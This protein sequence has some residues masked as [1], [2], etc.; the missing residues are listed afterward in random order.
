MDSI[1]QLP[2]S[3]ENFVDVLTLIFRVGLGLVI[4]PHGAQKLLGWY[5]GYGYKGTMGYFSSIGIPYI[6]GMLAIVAEFF[7]S[8]G[9]IFGFLTRISAFGIFFVMLVAALKVHIP[10]GFLM[11]WFGN[12]QGEGY[13]FHILAASI[14]LGLVILGGGAFSLDEVILNALQ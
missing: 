3:L 10:H 11:N 1:L 6:F 9:L 2:A 14:A 7:G 12:K 13:E 8:L 4:F 5:G